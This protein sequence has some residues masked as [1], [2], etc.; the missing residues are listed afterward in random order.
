MS[1]PRLRAGEYG[2]SIPAVEKGTVRCSSTGLVRAANDSRRTLKAC[3]RLIDSDGHRVASTL[4]LWL[5]SHKQGPIPRS[6]TLTQRVVARLPCIR[7]IAL[8]TTLTQFVPCGHVNS[9]L[10]HAR[11]AG[12]RQAVRSA[13]RAAVKRGR[14]AGPHVCLCRARSGVRSAAFSTPPPAHSCGAV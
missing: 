13:M 10:V 4:R 6:S 11:R 1:S 5:G 12:H 8:C 2:L 7:S 9:G 3:G 14:S